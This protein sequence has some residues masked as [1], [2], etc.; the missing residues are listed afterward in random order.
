VGTG[1]LCRCHPPCWLLAPH[2]LNWKSAG[3]AAAAARSDPAARELS[4]RRAVSELSW[5]APSNCS[6]SFNCLAASSS[7]ELTPSSA[8]ARILPLPLRP[9]PPPTPEDNETPG[10]QS[11]PHWERQNGLPASS[12]SAWCGVA[13]DGGRVG[14]EFLESVR[15]LWVVSCGQFGFYGEAAH[16]PRKRGCSVGQH[17]YLRELRRRTTNR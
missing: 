10:M 17:I 5:H 1:G 9:P 14:G 7:D 4:W 8:A 11:G 3:A 2:L 13:G 15:G 6:C 16:L 12:V